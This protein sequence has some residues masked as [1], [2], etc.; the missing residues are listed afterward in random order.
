M[1]QKHICPRCKDPFY[2][3]F[4]LESHQK[5]IK[6]CPKRKASPKILVECKCTSCDKV[7]STPQKLKNHMV[8]CP[9]V[10]NEQK[11]ANNSAN[12]SANVMGDNFG[13]NSVINHIT[14]VI[15]NRTAIVC[16]LTPFF[17]M[18]LNHS[19][20]LELQ[21]LNINPHI[22]L[23]RLVHC[24]EFRKSYHNVYY[25]DDNFSLIWV[26]NGERWYQQKF[27]KTMNEIISIQQ[28]ELD[29]F[30]LAW[31]RKISHVVSS[32]IG[33]HTKYIDEK[34]NVREAHQKDVSNLYSNLRNLMLRHNNVVE[35]TFS[36][37]R[38]D[39][40]ESKYVTG[41]YTSLKK[42][43]MPEDLIQKLVDICDEKKNI[44][45]G[46]PEEIIHK[47]KKPIKIVQIESLESK[48]FV[49]KKKGT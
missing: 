26:Y 14:N 47:K 35:R 10:I 39:S 32:H 46:E 6:T 15:V 9:V 27:I 1:I 28:K 16:Y 25:D 41:T 42:I 3:K 36:A 8:I 48:E 13:T 18:S 34:S 12:N 4:E 21:N 20:Q 37:S 22:T 44:E 7:L 43:G 19:E 24:N 33:G 17:A 49:S 40:F 30:L 45:T 2:T 11:I 23:F 5:K 31:H 29:K 38:D